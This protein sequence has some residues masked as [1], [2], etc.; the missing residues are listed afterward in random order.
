MGSKAESKTTKNARAMRIS[1]TLEKL[2]P[3]GRI[4]LDFTTPWECLAATILS[5]QCTDA[6]VNRVTPELFRAIPDVDA[7]GAAPLDKIEKLIVTTGFFRSKARSLKTCA[8]MIVNDF[9]G[10]LPESIEDLVRL[11]GVGRKT[12]NVILG[13][14]FGR[15]GFVVDT[16]VRRLT[17]R[18]GLT[19]ERDPEKIETDLTRILPPE[20]WTGFS[21]RLILHGR[22]VCYARGPKCDEC[23]LAPDCP[24]IGVIGKSTPKQAA[25]PPRRPK[26]TASRH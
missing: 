10:K 20:K 4:S 14:V 24:R 16:H 18:L 2:Y 1:A 7:M 26:R 11:P 17:Y 22:R 15:P 19:L 9:E 5:A 23:A 25:S 12:A 3:E 8:A 6:R 21:M 13:H